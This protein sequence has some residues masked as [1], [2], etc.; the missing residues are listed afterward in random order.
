M[1]TDYWLLQ[2]CDPRFSVFD[3]HDFWQGVIVTLT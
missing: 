2:Y 3:P 1:T